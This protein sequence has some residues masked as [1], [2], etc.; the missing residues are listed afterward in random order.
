MENCLQLASPAILSQHEQGTGTRLSTQWP[1]LSSIPPVQ[2]RERPGWISWEKP[3]ESSEH[4][5]QTVWVKW[6][7]ENDLGV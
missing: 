6:E 3:E 5:G 1:A 7:S 2:G 4:M